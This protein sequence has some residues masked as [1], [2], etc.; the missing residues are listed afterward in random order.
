MYEGHVGQIN[1]VLTAIETCAPLLIDGTSGRQ[2]LEL[3][4]GIL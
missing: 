4:T 3:I 1:N 2:T